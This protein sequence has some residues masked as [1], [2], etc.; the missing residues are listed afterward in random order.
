MT[1]LDPRDASA[2]AGVVAAWAGEHFG[3]PVHVG[4]DPI[5]IVGGFDSF[6]HVVHLTGPVLPDDWR[7][8]LVVRLLPSADRAAQAEREAAAQRWCGAQGYDVPRVLA[9]LDPS[10]GLGLPAQV[11]ERAPGTTMLVAITSRPWR[12][13][14]LV[15][16]LAGLALRLHALPTDGWPGLSDRFGTVDQR[17]GLPR[18]VV[19]ELD[20]PGLPEALARAEMLAPLA[21]GEEQVVCHG[22]FHPLNVLVDGDRASV[23]DWTDAA[24]GPREADVCRTLLLF[25]VAAVA[26]ESRLERT[27]LRLVGPQLERRYRRA[28]EPRARLDPVLLRRW[29]VLHAVHGWA[30][31]EMLHAGGFEGA[32]SAEGVRVP[33]GVIAFLRHRLEQALAALE[34]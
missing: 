25:N 23:V 32:S 22:D 29:E 21:V 31:A 10:E 30:Q 16:R 2:V 20:V 14:R 4:G 8:P 26:A 19:A 9:V 3:G 34:G 7:V 13:F 1:D 18:R 6:L 27:A 28:Y 11:M 17:L 15:D 24:L 12:A 33:A 5:A